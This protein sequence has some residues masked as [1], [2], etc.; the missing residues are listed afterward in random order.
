MNDEKF[1]ELNAISENI[2]TKFEDLKEKGEIEN[3]EFL[4]KNLLK[5]LP[6]KYSIEFSFNLSI[7]DSEREKSIEMLRVGINGLGNTAET[8][9][10]S[11]S[12]KFNRYLV[13][14]HIVEIPHNH[15]P[16]CWSEWDFKYLGS[17]CSDCGVTLGKEVKLLID[18]NECPNCESGKISPKKPHCDKCDFIAE[19]DLVIW[20]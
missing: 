6:E 5:K 16:N 13:Q 2:H 10:F 9:K 11:E 7:F 1:Y 12:Y 18:S 17:S 4:I 15:C 19:D 3:I 20:G 8:Y 14:G